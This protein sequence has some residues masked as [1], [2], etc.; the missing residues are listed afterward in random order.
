VRPLLREVQPEPA[1]LWIRYAPRQW[2]GPPGPWM[3]LA[4]GTF[5]DPLELCSGGDGFEATATLEGMG[6]RALDDLVYLPPVPADLTSAR[7]R[8]ASRHAGRGTP[9]L[10]QLLPGD[11]L[12]NVEGPCIA[13]LDL[14]AEALFSKA[15][16]WPEGDVQSVAAAVWPLLPGVDSLGARA[17]L[18]A[19]LVA[20]GVG[21]LQAVTLELDPRQL[22]ELAEDLPEERYLPLFHGNP[23]DAG[24]AARAAIAAGLRPLLPR[25]LPRPPL[26][27]AGNL[28]LAAVLATEGELCL[29]LGGA[30]PRAQSL[31]RAARFAE[32]APQDLEALARDG[33]LGVLPWLDAES[34]RVLEAALD[35]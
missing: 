25:P 30:E 18:L 4:A 15:L 31:L 5:A 7:D 26:R 3:D 33:N 24:D 14:T 35:G 32:R 19:T 22:R 12:P 6:D 8:L 21:T 20:A 11:P 27:G 23:P 34:R 29:R 16:T 17:D 9:V 13:V 2:P 28:R 10:V 1:K